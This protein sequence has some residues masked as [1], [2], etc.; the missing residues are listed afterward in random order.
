VV[1]DRVAEATGAVRTQLGDRIDGVEAEFRELIED[2]RERVIQVKGEADAKAPADHGHEEFERLDD[3]EADVA[4]LEAEIASLRESV[5][6]A[7][8]EHDVAVEDLEAEL[9]TVQERLRS[10]AWVANDLREAVEA[11]GME[12]VDRIKRAAAK[13]DVDR[14]RCESCGTGVEVALLT[15]P[16]CPHCDATVTDVEPATGFFDKPRLLV[17]AQLES[18]EDA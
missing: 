7:A 15:D 2:V 8:D 18:G 1:A 13:A 3:I 5:D 14:A 16:N 10:V 17:A 4:E 6:A 9:A 12:A 11:D